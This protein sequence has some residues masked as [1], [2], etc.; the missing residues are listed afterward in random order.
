M[1]NV[2]CTKL[3]KADSSILSPIEFKDFK[4]F[5]L[6]FLKEDMSYNSIFPG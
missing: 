3:V 5:R 2:D 1:S 6:R 4:K